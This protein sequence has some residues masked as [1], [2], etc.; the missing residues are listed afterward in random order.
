MEQALLISR[1]LLLLT[2]LVFHA[3][4]HRNSSPVITPRYY[5]PLIYIL[6]IP[7]RILYTSHAENKNRFKLLLKTARCEIP[8]FPSYKFNNTSNRTASYNI[9]SILYPKRTSPIYKTLLNR[10]AALNLIQRSDEFRDS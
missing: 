6:L 3:A 7:F 9:T 5:V 8:D 2:G 10:K 1:F 4:E